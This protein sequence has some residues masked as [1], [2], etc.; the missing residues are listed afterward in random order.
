VLF[1]RAI[2]AIQVAAEPATNTA[3]SNGVER[4]VTR[5]A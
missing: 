1:D 3:T 5:L 2:P 4:L